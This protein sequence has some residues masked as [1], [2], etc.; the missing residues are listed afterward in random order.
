MH[1]SGSWE[2][3]GQGHSPDTS[4]GGAKGGWGVQNYLAQR[5]I[6]VLVYNSAILK[7]Y[8]LTYYIDMIYLICPNIY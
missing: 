3:K 8:V 1:C 4:R 2:N 6:Y 5:L 7:V